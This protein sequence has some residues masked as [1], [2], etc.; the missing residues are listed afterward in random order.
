MHITCVSLCIQLHV[1]NWHGR[2]YVNLIHFPSVTGFER[3]K[4][5]AAEEGTHHMNALRG[6]GEPSCVMYAV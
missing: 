6:Y 3:E 2:R 1:L 4:N 5:S